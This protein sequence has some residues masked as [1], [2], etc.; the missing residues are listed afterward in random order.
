MLETTEIEYLSAVSEQGI[1]RLKGYFVCAKEYQVGDKLK[2]FSQT[3]LRFCG[4]FMCG[5]IRKLERG[6]WGG[7]I[8]EFALSRNRVFKRLLYR[9]L[10]ICPIH[11][12]VY[13]VSK[14]LLHM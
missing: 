14:K 7:W 1:T 13:R 9:I 6:Q 11:V 8:A 10:T 12:T 2:R 5:G 4:G 3:V